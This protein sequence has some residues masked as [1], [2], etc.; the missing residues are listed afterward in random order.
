LF[1]LLRFAVAFELAAD[2]RGSIVNPADG[3]ASLAG[4]ATAAMPVFIAHR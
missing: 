3:F 4:G 1:G 2:T